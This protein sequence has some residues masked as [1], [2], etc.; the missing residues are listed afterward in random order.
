MNIKLLLAFSLSLSFLASYA[1]EEIDTLQDMSLEDLLKVTVTTASKSEENIQ[2]APAIMN[3]ITAKE[4]ESFGANTLTDVLDRLTSVYLISTYFSPDGQLSMRG[5]QTDV[6]NTKVL[7]LLD[8][9]PLRESFHGGYNGVIYNM[10]P[11][12]RIERIEVI[13]GPGSVLYGT[14]AFV[15]VI[16]IVTKTG[17]NKGLTAKVSYGQFNTKQAA[18]SYG[19]RY[20]KFDVSGGLN[21]V[22]TDGWDFTARGESDVIRN[23]ANT[24]DSLFK[25]PKTIKRDNKGV[26][27]VLKIAYKNFTLNTF[28]AKNDWETMGRVPSWSNPIDYRIENNRYFS[29]LTYSRKMSKLW[30]TSLSATYNYMYYRS[31]NSSK[32][33][34]Y[35]RRG[36]SDVLFEFTNYIKPVSNLNIVVGGLA[37]IQSGKGIDTSY[38]RDGKAANIDTAPNADPWLTVPQYNYTWYA[39]YT[40]A[41]YSP[42][43]KIKLVAGAQM[44]KIDGKEAS[45]SP[46]FG[47]ILSANKNFGMK[48]LYG[49]AFRSPAAYERFGLSPGTV[50]GSASLTPEMMTTFETQV[51]YSTGKLSLSATYFHNHD[52]NSIQRINFKQTID[53]V[54]FTQSYTNTGYVNIGGIELEG[55][56]NV[57]PVNFTG[58][59]TFQRSEDNLN[60]VDRTGIP[61]RMGKLGIIYSYKKIGTLSVFNSIYGKTADYYQ[62]SSS[63]VNLTAAANPQVDAYNYM[64]ASL[65]IN[66]KELTSP[67]F[68]NIALNFMVNNLLDEK[69]Y[70]P[71]LV[72]R[73]INSLPGRPGRAMYAGLVF[74]F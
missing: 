22:R 26:S 50:A 37:N 29:D 64:S 21:I 45:V 39:A 30:T 14:A 19:N 33:D 4:I 8:S 72:R 65:H 34:D 32:A 56:Y 43:K 54:N 31:Y 49:N 15:G 47:L 73:N 10:F 66:L 12:E 35:V 25:D 7:I 5:T 70:Y 48:I 11:V 59:F 28:A 62:Y 60:L 58:S 2:Q 23:K 55:K 44:N 13:R 57:G 71:E 69:I 68:P 36:S 20:N 53:G 18:L 41:D 1:Q 67:K 6:F 74:K 16:N 24:A 38:G 40:Q 27:G 46:R 42:S 9:R 17:D 61:Q 63:N 52:A 51:N 3:I